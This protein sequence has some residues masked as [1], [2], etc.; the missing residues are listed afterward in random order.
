M[1]GIASLTGQTLGP[2]DGPDSFDQLAALLGKNSVGRD[3]LVEQADVLA[4]I[5]GRWKYIEP[6]NEQAPQLYD[7]AADIGEKKS[8]AA[9]NADVDGSLAARLEEIRR[10]GRSRP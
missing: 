7:L 10:D 6:G 1:T 2:D 3:H 8:V 5:E 4:L 9:E